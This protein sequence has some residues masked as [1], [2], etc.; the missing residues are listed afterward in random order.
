MKVVATFARGIDRSGSTGYYLDLS[1]L[2]RQEEWEEPKGRVA[3]LGL[4]AGGPGLRL[5][6]EYGPEDGA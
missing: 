5:H 2:G 4:Q 1:A 3:A 6:D